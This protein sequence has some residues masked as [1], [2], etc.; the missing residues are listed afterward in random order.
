[1]MFLGPSLLRFIRGPSTC[2]P[3]ALWHPMSTR[4]RSC[5]RN[6]VILFRCTVSFAPYDLRRPR[7]RVH[8]AL[9]QF[10]PCRFLDDRKHTHFSFPTI[11]TRAWSWCVLDD[12]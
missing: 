5:S 10:P 6:S 4:K 7:A 2:Q 9:L 8:H 12:H 1:M 11:V 3:R